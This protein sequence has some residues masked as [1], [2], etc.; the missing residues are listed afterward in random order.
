M[1]DKTQEGHAALSQVLSDAQLDEYRNMLAEH[2][3]FAN[4]RVIKTEEGRELIARQIRLIETIIGG[5]PVTPLPT[6]HN[7]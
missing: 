6:R 7:A 3:A 5:K 4:S 1:S 2:K